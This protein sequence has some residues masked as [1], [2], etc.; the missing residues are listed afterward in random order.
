MWDNMLQTE[1]DVTGGQTF[2]GVGT[3]SAANGPDRAFQIDHPDGMRLLLMSESGSM[4][5]VYLSYPPNGLY[6]FRSSSQFRLEAS[7]GYWYLKCDSGSGIQTG[8]DE[9]TESVQLYHRC[10]LPVVTAQDRYVLYVEEVNAQSNVCH[11]YVVLSDAPLSIGRAQDNDIVYPVSMVSRHHAY[12]TRMGDRWQIE[13]C[14]SSNGVFVN[15]YRV[16]QSRLCVGD[17]LSIMGLKIVI[18]SGYLSVNDGNNRVQMSPERMLRVEDGSR[19][20]K[21]VRPDPN[22]KREGMFNRLPRRR[23]PME[24]K[25]IELE[26]PPMPMNSEKIPMIMRMGHSVVTGGAAAVT[27]N[28]G[29]LATMLALPVLRQQFTKEEREEYEEK[30]VRKYHEYLDEKW[31]EILKEK[32]AEEN[33]LRCNYPPLEEVLT[34]TRSRERLWERRKTDDDFLTLRLGYGSIPLKAEI[35]SQ[36]RHFD[37]EQDPLLEEMYDVAETEVLLENVP[38][39]QD[40]KADTVWGIEGD[41]ASSIE[42]VRAMIMRIALLYSYDEVKILFLGDEETLKELE[43]VTSLPHAWD[44]QRSIRFVA[45]DVPDVYQIGEY[46]SR[47]LDQDLEKKRM[48]SEMMKDHPY[49]VVFALSKKLLDSMEVLKTLFSLEENRGVTVIAACEDLPKEC[50]LLINVGGGQEHEHSI[51]YLKQIDR[52]DQMFSSDPYE[53]RQAES[54][55][56]QLVGIRLRLVSQAYTLPKTLTFLEMFGAGR[57]EH[58]DIARRWRENNPCTSLAVPIG[59]ATDGTDFML[60]LHQKFQGPHGLVA[61]TT[62]SGKSEFLLTYILSL[63][64]SFHPDE[65]AFVLIDYKGGGLA[66]AFDDPANG[67]HLPHLI[68][69]ITNLDGSA[70]ARSLTSIQSEMTRRQKEFNEA[71]SATGEGTMDIYTYQ[72]LYRNGKV[73]KSMP[74]LF[75]ISDEFAELKQQQPEF[76]DALVSIARIGRSLGVHLILATQKPSGV[77]TGQIVSNTKFRVCL[78]VQDKSDSRDMLGR[79]EAADLREAG[80]FYLQVGNNELFALGQSAW[81]GAEYEPQDQVVTKKDDSIE[82]VDRIGSDILELR[83]ERESVGTGRSQ[84]VEIVKAVTDLA[85]QMGIEKRSLWLPALEERIDY[86]K[87]EEQY[88]YEDGCLSY[89]A[90]LVDDPADQKQ[91]PRTLDLEREGG[92]LVAGEPGAGKTTFLQ[93]ML[94]SLSDRYSPEDLQFY[95]LDYSSRL[96]HLYRKLPHCGAVLE[97]EDE[98]LLNSFFKL[99]NTLVRERKALFTQLE[100]DNFEAARKRK[101]IPLILVVIDNLTGLSATR[102]GRGHMDQLKEYIKNA[103]SYGIRYVIT[104]S[105]LND[106]PSRIRQELPVRVAIHMKDHYDYTEMIG[107][108][109]RNEPADRPGRGLCNHD[110]TPLEMQ[111]AMF[112]P[113]KDEERILLLKDGIEKIAQKYRDDVPA[114]RLKVFSETETYEQFSSQF[115]SGRIPLGYTVEESNPVA[116]PIKQLSQLSVYFGN[117]DSTGP[118]W[119]N[120][121]SA[122]MREDM[123]LVMLQSKNGTHLDHWKEKDR[124]FSF[125]GDEEGITKVQQLMYAVISK[126]EPI[127]QE[128]CTANSTTPESADIEQQSFSWM[129]EHVKPTLLVIERFADLCVTT[130]DADELVA[131][132]GL[133]FQLA[134]RYQIY[135]IGGFY[136]GDSSAVITNQIF[137]RFNPQKMCMLFGGMLSGQCLL[138]GLSSMGENDKASAYN[139]CIMSY[140]G[141]IHKLMMPCGELKEKVLPEDDRPIF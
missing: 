71:K 96:F 2:G 42:F 79:S 28:F 14:G 8:G 26:S 69:T 57:I 130:P 74:H 18:G 47:S 33:V 122:A 38:I 84:L 48:F 37:V 132:Y 56:R 109:V 67:I 117:P 76:L 52:P 46:L 104:A 59:V 68:A 6:S 64:V 19:I 11:N 63:A 51:T 3:A 22:R 9:F 15:G 41:R 55:M 44:D 87:L 34:Y 131:K 27:G 81:S 13:D 136:P 121:I 32:E 12:L 24:Q 107:C 123:S 111:L 61:G 93:T 115:R 4:E 36:K 129:R 72:R 139:R 54:V 5:Q 106:C 105:H 30:R 88:P 133:I 114:A 31:E 50:S 86:R 60:D 43:F 101:H 120:L 119:D 102:T 140:R 20:C 95:V 126:R 135:I 66:G 1:Y 97:E 92:I 108:R 113:D 83:P 73:S 62:G 45:T 125:A 80:R 7:G 29:V 124:V 89:T 10:M 39:L 21:T 40:L 85:K 16:T 110:G 98:G 90:G 99:I 77:V 78:K 100:V 70:I 65:V 94:Y 128:F 23:L 138:K 58:L 91:F 25:H 141:D 53:R 116:L 49:Y 17:E 35:S 103:S 75:I 137:Q 82:V 118:V 134:K 127:L 112:E